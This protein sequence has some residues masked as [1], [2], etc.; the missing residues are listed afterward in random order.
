MTGRGVRH[1]GDQCDTYILDAEF[2]RLWR[3]P[4]ARQLFPGWW[5]EA[6]VT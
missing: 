3:S 1:P 4:A 2:A 6:V 5:R